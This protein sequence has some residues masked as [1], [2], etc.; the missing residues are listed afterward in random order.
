MTALAHAGND[1]P[2]AYVAQGG[3][4]FLESLAQR[5]AGILAFV[6]GA[7]AFVTVWSPDTSMVGESLSD[8]ALDV[9][10]IFFLGYIAYNAFRIW[11]DNK[12]REEQGDEEPAELGDEGGGTSASR[13]ATL[14]PLF[15]NFVLIVIV[16]TVLLTW[17]RRN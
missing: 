6:A 2:P 1:R 16:V 13:L 14:L 9:M 5:V 3:N 15:R 12:I 7:Y 8:R 10:V 11:I 4:G 17:R